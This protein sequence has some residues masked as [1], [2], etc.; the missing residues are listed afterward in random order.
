MDNLNNMKVISNFKKSFMYER[1]AA[2]WMK[3]ESDQRDPDNLKK[4]I[5][6]LYADYDKDC[7]CDPA[8]W[9]C[10]GYESANPGG[11]GCCDGENC[12]GCVCCGVVLCLM[13]NS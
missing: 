9:F 10:V 7:D 2:Q 5:I 8:L 13:C 3:L 12:C 6:S 4:M 1:A 11:L